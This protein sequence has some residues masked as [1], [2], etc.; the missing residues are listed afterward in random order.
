[1][2]NIVYIYT[3]KNVNYVIENFNS[4]ILGQA[5]NIQN[6][7]SNFIEIY[8]VECSDTN[9]VINLLHNYF[10]EYVIKYSDNEVPLYRSDII[11]YIDLVMK[12]NNITFKK[13]S[14]ESL[15]IIGR[16]NKVR[17]IKCYKNML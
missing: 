3:Y 16:I 2:K 6:I 15:S 5:D 1:M 11:Y 4:Y 13:L 14:Q 12:E 10:K 8:K 17:N 9:F 7:Q